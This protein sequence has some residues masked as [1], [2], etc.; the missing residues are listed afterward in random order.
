MNKAFPKS[1]FPAHKRKISAIASFLSVLIFAKPVLAVA[2]T[3]FALTN[4]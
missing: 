1:S 2:I 3:E 4:R